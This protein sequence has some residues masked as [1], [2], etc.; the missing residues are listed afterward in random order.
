MALHKGTPLPPKESPTIQ[1]RM[2]RK[3]FSRFRPA[4]HTL[5]RSLED[6]DVEGEMAAIQ[7]NSF[8]P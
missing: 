2:R 4:P 6:I 8:L 1:C 3:A 7:V 5:W